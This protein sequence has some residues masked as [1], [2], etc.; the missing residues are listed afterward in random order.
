VA[1][2]VDFLLANPDLDVFTMG[3]ILLSAVRAG[4]I[5]S[6]SEAGSGDVEAALQGLFADRIAAARQTESVSELEILLFIAED[7]G[8]D[9]LAYDALAALVAIGP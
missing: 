9:D 7:L 3:Q 8:W 1:R 5:G 4:V 6:G 2:L